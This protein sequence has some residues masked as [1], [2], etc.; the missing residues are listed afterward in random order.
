MMRHRHY[1][2]SLF[3]VLLALAVPPALVAALVLARGDQQHYLRVFAFTCAGVAAVFG[4]VALAYRF[5]RGRARRRAAAAVLL[6]AAGAFLA[7]A[8]YTLTHL[9]AIHRQTSDSAPGQGF[10]VVLLVAGPL[11]LG[12]LSGA[13]GWRVWRG[14]PE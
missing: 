3:L 10:P 14:K 12:A 1:Q 4:G 11:L 2:P 5:C 6:G 7:A 13:I 8:G 9:G